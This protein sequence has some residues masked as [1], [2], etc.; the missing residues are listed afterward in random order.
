MDEWL[1]ILH[2]ALPEAI[3]SVI[4][5]VVLALIGAVLARILWLYRKGLRRMTGASSNPP[6]FSPEQTKELLDRK[7]Q[8][9]FELKKQQALKGIDTEP[10]ISIEIKDLEEEIRRLERMLR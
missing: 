9:L 4:A 7:R 10:H 2:E 3:G 5:A 8:R 6:D 1:L